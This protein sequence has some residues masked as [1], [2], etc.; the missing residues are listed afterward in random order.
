MSDTKAGIKLLD[1]TLFALSG[2]LYDID[3][4]VIGA[5][6]SSFERVR[7]L[8]GKHFP[9]GG[10]RLALHE[11]TASLQDCP[12]VREIASC[13]F[14][15]L[16]R[17]GVYPYEHAF[18][19]L[20]CEVERR[21]V[22]GVAGG[23]H[24]AVPE[25]G[26]DKMAARVES[27]L[28]AR[29]FQEPPS[30]TP[31]IQNSSSFGRKAGVVWKEGQPMRPLWLKRFRCMRNPF[32]SLPRPWMWPG[33]ALPRGQQIRRLAQFRNLKRHGHSRVWTSSH[34]HSKGQC[35]WSVH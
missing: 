6:G 1:R 21:G 31:V 15:A 19:T 33:F 7:E 4:V 20:V 29:S 30:L 16:V 11:L 35:S 3:E 10:T 5:D 14:V 12:D 24:I 25:E 2:S 26:G 28:R 13:R 9:G 27:W 22:P 23:F 32:F 8:F 34:A 18:S 17:P